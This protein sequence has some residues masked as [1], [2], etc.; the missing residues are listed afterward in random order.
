[1]PILKEQPKQQKNALIQVRVE[2][3][4]K[5]DLDLYA[6]FIHSNQAWVV[7]E[8]LKFLFKKDHEF[9]DWKTQNNNHHNH[10]SLEEGEPVKAIAKR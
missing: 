9:Q 10:E 5:T 4:I 3:E 1:L 6:E 7:S 2:D 8:A